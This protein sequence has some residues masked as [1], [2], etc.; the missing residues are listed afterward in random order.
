[1]HGH[2]VL[3]IHAHVFAGL[4]LHGRFLWL[5]DLLTAHDSAP[6]A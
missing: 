5:M 6:L 2:A 3:D 1:M 4:R